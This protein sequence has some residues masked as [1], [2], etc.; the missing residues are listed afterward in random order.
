MAEIRKEKQKQI[1]RN[2]NNKE[3]YLKKSNRN[4]NNAMNITN[5]IKC[6]KR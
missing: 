3:Q 6:N 2:K 5:K 4:Q 1:I